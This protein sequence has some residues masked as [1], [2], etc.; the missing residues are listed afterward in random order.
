MTEP[1]SIYINFS[2]KYPPPTDI[3]DNQYWEIMEKKDA[4]NH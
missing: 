3:D 4:E 1:D 2:S